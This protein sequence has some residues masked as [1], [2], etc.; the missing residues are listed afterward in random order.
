MRPVRTVGSL[1]V[2]APDNATISIDGRD[3][4]IGNGWRSDSLKPGTY[5]VSA[6]VPSASGCPTSTASQSVVVRA[7]SK[8]ARVR[9]SPRGCALLSFDAAPK[10]SRYVLTSLTPGD[11]L[12]ARRGTAPAERLLL[13]VGDYSRVISFEKCADYADTV[14]VGMQEKLPRRALLCR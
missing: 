6:S 2:E 5:E 7:T 3:Q 4:G 14:H 13:P 12:P 8:V 1:V 11:T 9:L 10:G